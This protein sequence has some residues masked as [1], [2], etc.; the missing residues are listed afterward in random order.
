MKARKHIVQQVAIS[1][2]LLRRT[3]SLASASS[4]SAKNASMA[5][6]SDSEMKPVVPLH[7]V[8]D[9]CRSPYWD[10]TQDTAIMVVD[11]GEAITADR[12]EPDA[13]GFMRGHWNALGIAALTE[14]K[15]S[16]GL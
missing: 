2:R 3:S 13:S 14:Q 5:S 6:A 1:R 9:A 8:V 15:G 7:A 4:G 12:V 10:E 11:H 16:P